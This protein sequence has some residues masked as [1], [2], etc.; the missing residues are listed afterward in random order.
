MAQ[1]REKISKIKIIK[2][3]GDAPVFSFT[4]DAAGALVTERFDIAGNV[5]TGFYDGAHRLIFVLDNTRDDKIPNTLLVMESPDGR[6]WDDI[7]VND[8]GVDLET[9]RPRK[10]NRY[11]KLDIDYDGL[12]IYGQ[13]VADNMSGVD[14]SGALSALSDYRAA[15]GI[16]LAMARLDAARR[17]IAV[18][19]ATID[20][21]DTGLSE[22]R[23][24]M[25]D[26]KNK[27]SQMRANVGKKPNKVVA[28]KILKLE[29]DLEAMNER[30][31]RARLRLRRAKKRL[32]DANSDADT[33]QLV[34][35]RLGDKTQIKTKEEKM[36]NETKPLFDK[37]PNIIDE[38]IAFK[39]IEFNTP[40]FVPPAME[41][42]VA[43]AEIIETP[44]SQDAALPDGMVLPKPAPV[45][46]PIQVA[47]VM[48]T[49]TPTSMQVP[50]VNPETNVAQSSA[51]IAAPAPAVASM[52]KPMSPVTGMTSITPTTNNENSGNKP[53]KIYYIMLIILIALAI[54]TLW[55]YQKNMDS[56]VTPN[57]VATTPDNNAPETAPAAVADESAFIITQPTITPAAES[58]PVVAPAPMPESAPVSE[59]I[60]EPVAAIEEVTSTELVVHPVS[61]V[62]I[63]TAPMVQPVQPV[64]LP[65][66]APEFDT[67]APT[68]TSPDNV[69]PQII[70][71]ESVT[72]VV[73]PVED[74][75]MTEQPSV[76]SSLC[77]S[78]DA[79]DVN[80]CCAG[81]ESRWIESYNAY[82]CCSIM[83]GECYPPLK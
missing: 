4:G 7:L 73:A 54:F 59:A 65:A 26:T 16:R 23:K 68:I 6:K 64:T 5:F 78:G 20:K 80:G 8:Y 79:P 34:L 76:S 45:A 56:S 35:K 83:D 75:A 30:S 15:T 66:P 37:D 41:T 49:A 62:S 50:I 19:S 25:R 3:Q 1:E 32:A 52:Q 82:G 69:Q 31:N 53:T 21:T 39:P 29:S 42:P 28:A 55:M 60:Q 67:P 48:N 2:T 11:E 12:G 22:L 14:L 33:A 13:L 81:E 46:D 27:I 77:T 44:V 51:P 61:D 24:K 43:S 63:E 18:A 57:L 9:I 70:V 36:E 38:K 47:P 10:N 40:S 74:V 58:V 71:D 17:E 72:E